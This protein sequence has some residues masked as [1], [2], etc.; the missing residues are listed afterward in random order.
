MR[1]KVAWV[2]VGAL[3]GLMVATVLPAGAHHA[4]S[5]D[6]LKTRVSRLE[7]AVRTLQRQTQ[8]LDPEFGDYYGFVISEQ[9]ISRCDPGT[10]AVWEAN[11]FDPSADIQWI[12]DCFVGE[13]SADARQK[14]MLRLFERR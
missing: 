12:D 5:V 1:T 8:L 2:I 9:V 7:S 13:Q 14:D 6:R 10:T 11:T 4:S 3:V